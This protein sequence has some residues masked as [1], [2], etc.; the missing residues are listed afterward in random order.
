MSIIEATVNINPIIGALISLT[1]L[2]IYATLGG[3]RAV[4]LTDTLQFI[5]LVIGIP[6]TFFIGLHHV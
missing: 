4:V 2:L 1:V 5:I 3:M 6:L